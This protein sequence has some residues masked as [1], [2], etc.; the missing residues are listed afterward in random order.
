[1]NSPVGFVNL[2]VKRIMFTNFIFPHTVECIYTDQK[3]IQNVRSWLILTVHE[4]GRSSSC[5]ATAYNMMDWLGLLPLVDFWMIFIR[6]VVNTYIA[7]KN[8]GYSPW[9]VPLCLLVTMFMLYLHASR[10]CLSYVYFLN[11]YSRLEH[12]HTH[13]KLQSFLPSLCIFISIYCLEYWSHIL[14]CEQFC[15]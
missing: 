14:S 5:E 11:E 9:T 1:M 3:S 10:F 15:V 2:F 7:C 8:D 6:S 12:S 4:I 13:K